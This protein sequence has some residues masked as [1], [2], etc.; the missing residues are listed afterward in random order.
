[1]LRELASSS[2]FQQKSQ[3]FEDE[4]SS[5]KLVSTRNLHE[6]LEPFLAIADEQQGDFE[7]LSTEDQSIIL[8]ANSELIMTFR[9]YLKQEAELAYDALDK[10]LLPSNHFALF[11][12]SDSNPETPHIIHIIEGRLK[13]QPSHGA[14]INTLL[15]IL[16]IF[17]VLF[18][19]AQIAIGELSLTDPI[20]ADAMGTSILS[21]L[22]EIW[23]GYPYALSIMA[24]LIAH[25]LGHYLMMRYHK[26][27]SSLP[28]FIPA[29][30]IS[31]LGTLGA[32]I[33]LKDIPKNRKIL[34]D[35]GAA[36]PIAGFIVALPLVI[37]GLS[38]SSI[39]PLVAGQYMEGNSLIY[40]FAKIVALGEV[41][42]TNTADVLINQVAFAGW[43]GLL[44][45]SFQMIPLGQL[46]GGH[47]LYSLLGDKAR[48]ALYPVLL[49]LVGLTL[50]TGQPAW[51]FYLALLFILGR[52]YAM[53]L[54]S[55][56]ALNPMRQI[57]GWI[58]LS[59]FILTFTPVLATV[60]SGVASTDV[61]QWGMMVTIALVVVRQH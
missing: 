42:P 3:L 24:I 20:V 58:A 61:S 36:G 21:I 37:Y 33:V 40:L 15:F 29:W 48:L 23:R 1:M 19:G 53:P 38:T 46:D 56:T 32:A 49:A 39:V 4:S 59:I 34:L 43:T 57:I 13:K 51:L 30:L 26:M 14:W 18:T 60:S 9:G 45:T 44:L 6:M 12:Q 10:L 8:H 50:W 25:E 2:N 22:R 11:R 35:I 55:I 5:E 54:D 17:S 27:Q 7:T 47:V 52:Y 31:S 41:Y 16:T 28:Y